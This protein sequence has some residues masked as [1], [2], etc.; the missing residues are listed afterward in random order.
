[1]R[2]S[3]DQI[4]SYLERDFSEKGAW[5]RRGVRGARIVFALL[6]DLTDGQLSLRAMSL[7]YTT[8]ITLVPL[9]AIS[10]SVLKGFGVHNQIEPWLLGFLSP[11][12]PQGQEIAEKVIG[13]VDNVKV[14]VLGAVG[15][16]ALIYSV[17]SLMQK[18]E[19]SFNY[20]WR[21]SKSR[22]FARRFS[23]YLSV[24]LFGPFLLFLS[25]GLTATVRGNPIVERFSD[26]A[27]M[28]EAVNVLTF[29]VPY[30]IMTAGF[31]FFY[32]YMPNTRVRIGPAITGGLFTALVW[33]VM[34]WVFTTFVLASGKYVAIYA[35][36]ATLILFMM[37][38]YFSWIVVLAGANLA[39]YM[40]N[41]KYLSISRRPVVL[42]SRTRRAMGFAIVE[43]L[44]KA[45][46]EHGAGMDADAVAARFQLPAVATERVFMALENGG[47]ITPCATGT[48][49]VYFPAKP[50]DQMTM[51][52]VI[53]ALD[54][55]GEEDGIG[56]E[57]TMISPAL[58]RL[59][60]E[61][62]A[63]LEVV[64]QRSVKDVFMPQGAA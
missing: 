59:D 45:Q 43:A 17:V 25:A 58:A 55:A 40:Q 12:G 44:V 23:D 14:G 21:V 29:L 32:V 5:V 56:Y 7:V 38:V 31:T 6:R 3:K 57:R 64:A 39:F 61:I 62:E 15:L 1:M 13:F 34:G 46:Y 47:I 54:R 22:G 10:F 48:R 16:L 18:I 37:W 2:L 33:K 53:A 42:S 28:Q 35:A 52:E 49:P 41:P 50:L 19:A 20:I 24:L 60:H 27:A 51:G 9:L 4:S 11:L 26:V 63:A 8:L 30:L 36:F